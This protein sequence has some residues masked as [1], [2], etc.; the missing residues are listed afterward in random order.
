[1]SAEIARAIFAWQT[2]EDRRLWDGAIMALPE[3]AFTIDTGYS[4]GSLQRECV[5]VVD[6]MQAS[7]ERVQS[8]KQTTSAVATEDPTRV[9]VRAIWDRVEADWRSWFA[10]LDDRGFQQELEIVYR[11]TAMTVPVWQTIFHFFNHNTLHRAEM[12]QMVAQLGGAAEPER[13]F[14]AYCLARSG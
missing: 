5:H 9:Q 10:R 14:S 8:I 4:W 11:D 1:M 12:R 6:V 3:P 13:S 2:R 7:L